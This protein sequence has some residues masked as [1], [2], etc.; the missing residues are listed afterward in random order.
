MFL[1]ISFSLASILA[2]ACFAFTGQGFACPLCD[3]TSSTISEDINASE[4]AVIAKSLGTDTATNNTDLSKTRFQIMERL[5][6]ATPSRELEDMLQREQVVFSNK[7]IA[8]GELFL[9]FAYDTVNLEW[10]VPLNI[11]A[12][13]DTYIRAV[14]KL[15]TEQPDRLRFF[16]KHLSSTD[17]I[18][19]EDAYN[20][21]AKTS[22]DSI[23][24]IQEDLD[25]KQIIS[26]INDPATKPRLRGLY[27]MLLSLV[28][29]P[30]D[31]ALCRS[32]LLKTD[33]NEIT[34]PID[35]PANI[36]CMVKLGGESAMSEIDARFL[37]QTGIPP[38]S[39]TKP[40]PMTLATGFDTPI[41]GKPAPEASAIGSVTISPKHSAY[42]AI[43]TDP[44]SLSRSALKSPSVSCINA[45]VSAIRVLEQE[46]H[47]LPKDRLSASLRL[48][49][50]RE[51]MADYVIPD[52]ARWEDWSAM[53]RL[54]RLFYESNTD[55]SFVRIPI[56]NYM[57][58]CP[59]PEA[60]KLLT[61]MEAFDP[62]SAE[63]AAM[64]F[65]YEVPEFPAT[66]PPSR[67][68]AQ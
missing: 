38:A 41:V 8:E 54:D 68:P 18:A 21:F 47:A 30:E 49:L 43:K 66:H 2:S 28:G 67:K 19:S 27:W 45:V 53:E 56:F 25:R 16:L 65:G 11:L 48:V 51:E 32:F 52:L 15:S 63:R 37:K 26:F 17:D 46:L 62:K 39:Q 24:S 9:L 5:K 58:I 14:S 44:S 35:L 42:D 50:E 64:L 1:K 36:A 61:K 7:P 20:E 10:G 23:R 4:V 3:A 55:S 40:G 34:P 13:A 31:V 57:R 59:R 22:M 33:V 6:V 12:I 60:K 29:K